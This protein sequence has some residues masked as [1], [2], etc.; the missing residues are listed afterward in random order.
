MRLFGKRIDDERQRRLTTRLGFLQARA[1][2][3][4]PSLGAVVQ[5]PL[6]GPRGREVNR[7]LTLE[8]RSQ[9]QTRLRGSSGGVCVR[10][11][12]RRSQLRYLRR[13]DA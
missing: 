4:A 6:L 13:G 10:R 9:H 2:T 3:P 5:V 1:P 12:Q 11:P 8:D 7:R